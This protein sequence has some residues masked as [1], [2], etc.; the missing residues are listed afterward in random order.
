[1]KRDDPQAVFEKFIKDFASVNDSGKGQH[2]IHALPGFRD[3]EVALNV[4]H[5]F[6][7]SKSH[8]VGILTNTRRQLNGLIKG[9]NFE[10]RQ[11]DI[12][13]EL[14]SLLTLK[15]NTFN[16]ITKKIHE[17]QVK[18]EMEKDIWYFTTP[19]REFSEGTKVIPLHQKFE[20][21]FIKKESR[22]RRA[23]VILDKKCSVAAENQI[24]YI[25]NKVFESE[26]NMKNVLKLA[27]IEFVKRPVKK[28]SHAP[29]QGRL[30][31]RLITLLRDNF[32]VHIISVTAEEKNVI[33]AYFQMLR[34]LNEFDS[35]HKKLEEKIVSYF[36]KNAPFMK[37]S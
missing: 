36:E 31:A 2:W 6:L 17:Q 33:M 27:A 37:N 15:M 35:E 20:V 23:F 18:L 7:K 3:W 13:E 22:Y 34:D 9:V 30:P 24:M 4:I 28:K 1:M 19:W 32:S 10:R 8:Y 29:Y 5:L 26:K 11:E 16:D 21:G 14:K 25:I 12:S